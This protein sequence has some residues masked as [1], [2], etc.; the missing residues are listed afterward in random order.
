MHVYAVGAIIDLGGTELE[1]VEQLVFDP[2]LSQVSFNRQ[3]GL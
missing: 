2:A 1:E 3:P